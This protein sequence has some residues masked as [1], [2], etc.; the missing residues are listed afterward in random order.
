MRGTREKAAHHLEDLEHYKEADDYYKDFDKLFQ[1]F[2]VFVE[3]L[4]LLCLSRWRNDYRFKDLRFP[5]LRLSHFDLLS[6]SGS[7]LRG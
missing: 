1:V 2:Y 6:L 4:G 7:F 5:D 3:A